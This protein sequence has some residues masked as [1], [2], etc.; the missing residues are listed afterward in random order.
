MSDFR[1][2]VRGA[3][4]NP[5]WKKRAD[6]SFEK[7]KTKTKVHDVKRVKS[8]IKSEA[9][10]EWIIN[11]HARKMPGAKTPLI[12]S[13]QSITGA[14][15]GECFAYMILDLHTKL[16]YRPDALAFGIYKAVKS[17]WEAANKRIKDLE[18]DNG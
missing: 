2:H 10:P 1:Q 15:L 12:S 4:K 11:I 7:L 3:P 18:A 8:P 17:A 6:F 14:Q 16:S 9:T 5:G 13:T